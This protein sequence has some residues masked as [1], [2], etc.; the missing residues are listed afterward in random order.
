MLAFKVLEY[1][2][3]SRYRFCF[4]PRE[5]DAAVCRD[6]DPARSAP[7]GEECTASGVESWRRRRAAEEEEE[8]KKE[9]TT[10]CEDEEGDKKT[11]TYEDEDEEE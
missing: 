1:F 4:F 7:L 10:N 6:A 9:K 8:E 11:T 2:L 3:A 5:Y